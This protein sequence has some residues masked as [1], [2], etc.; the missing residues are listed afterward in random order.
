MA[1]TRFQL[2]HLNKDNYKTWSHILKHHF[3]SMSYWI[4][5][6][7]GKKKKRDTDDDWEKINSAA[8]TTLLS[9]INSN[10]AQNIDHLGE[11]SERWKVLKVIYVGLSTQRMNSLQ[12]AFFGFELGDRTIDQ[13][14]AYLTSLQAPD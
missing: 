7:R 11:A 3:I 6:T 13:V 1:E 4:V 14:A 10:Q 8:V 12:Q 9:V 2:L 5:V